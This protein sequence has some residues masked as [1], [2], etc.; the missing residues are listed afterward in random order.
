VVNYPGSIV[1]TLSWFNTGSYQANNVVISDTIFSG[2]TYSTSSVAPSGHTGPDYFWDIG[3]VAAN[4]NGSMTLTV[5]ENPS[6]MSASNQFSASGTDF[7]SV[8]SNVVNIG[9]GTAF[10]VTDSPT[11]TPSASPTSTDT[12]TFTLSSTPSDTLTSTDT[13]TSTVTPSDTPTYTSSASPPDTPTYTS[14][15]SPTDTPT[16]T[17]SASPTSTWTLSWTPSATPTATYSSSATPTATS[18]SSASATVSATPTYSSTDSPTDTPTSTLT[19]TSSASPTVTPTPTYTFAYQT[20]ELNISMSYTGNTWPGNGF[21]TYSITFSNNSC[22]SCATPSDLV[23]TFNSDTQHPGTGA[24][25]ELNADA[26]TCLSYDECTGPEGPGNPNNWTPTNNSNAILTM[27]EFSLAPG[28]PAIN[29]TAYAIVES[30][31]LNQTITSQAVLSSNLWFTSVTTTV[32]IYISAVQPV[33]LPPTPTPIAF[34]GYTAAYPQPA[35]DHLCIAYFAPQ[36]GPLTIEIYNLAFKR[37][38]VITDQSQ[39]G[40][41]ETACVGISRLAPGLYFYRAKVGDFTFPLDRFGVL[42]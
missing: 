11:D 26:Q 13:F 18:S 23:L 30:N 3:T 2:Q 34:E 15:A 37:V 40:H 8:S 27:G 14:S 24:D 21:L 9:F 31:A 38:A 16:S 1:Y 41:M 42:R 4:G 12:P 19:A 7:S 22:A 25:N 20:P 35:G 32:N 39:G 28:A 5:N 33:T 29:R 36:G 6:E 17:S 10:T